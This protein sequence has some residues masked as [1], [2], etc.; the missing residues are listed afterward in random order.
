VAGLDL[1]GEPAAVLVPVKS[2]A[3]AKLRLAPAL[4]AGERARLARSFATRVVRAAAPLPVAVA[5]DNE[6]VAAWA[7][8][9]GAAV[10]WTPGLGLNGAVAAG[11]A[12]LTA[13]GATRVVVAHGD[14][15]F[16]TGL[17]A[18]ATGEG[19]TL[20]PDRHE[21]GTN[22]CCVPSR[23]G[24]AFS[25]GPGSFLR[26]QAEATRLGLPLTVV[27]SAELGLDVDEPE[28][29]ALARRR[30]AAPLRGTAASARGATAVPA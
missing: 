30:S 15:P 13:R 14:L 20:V 19:V 29:L 17:A 5:C 16:A 27:R 11:V 7:V 9:E 12:F 23:A 25:Y 26:H 6:E 21:R 3:R 22:V 10:C 24:F 18:L 28:D 4:E 8:G 1:L 2:F